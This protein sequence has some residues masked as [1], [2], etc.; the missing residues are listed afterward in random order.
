VG[1]CVRIWAGPADGDDGDGDDGDGDDDDGDGVMVIILP[2]A[3][4]QV[5]WLRQR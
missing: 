2:E 3:L 5:G 4:R 1:V